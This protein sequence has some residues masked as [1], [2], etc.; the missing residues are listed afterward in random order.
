M[1]KTIV[2]G[3]VL[4][5]ILMA[6]SAMPMNVSAEPEYVPEDNTLV[7]EHLGFKVTE[8]DPYGNLLWSYSNSNYAFDAEYLPN[9]NILY[10]YYMGLVEFDENQNIIWSYDTYPLQPVDVERLDNGNTLF[11]GT[12]VAATFGYAIEIDY[13]KNEV[14]KMND[15][16]M[17]ADIERLPNGNNLISEHVG[18]RV[19]EYDAYDE[20]V[21]EM[22]DLDY[23]HDVERLENGNTLIVHQGGNRV[24]EVETNNNNNIV[25]EYT[26]L[27]CP[28]D[29]ERL[30]NG[31][32]LIA[33]FWNGRVIE[34]DK[35]KNIVWEVTGLNTPHDVERD[36]PPTPEEATE[37]LISD[38][39]DLDLPDGPETSLVSKLEMAI[40]SLQ[41]DKPSA[42][43]Q[44]G[45]FINEV[46]AQRGKELTTEQADYLIAAA[47]K[48]LNNI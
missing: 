37:S 15:L 43:G 6:F 22:L 14:W 19:R 28:K 2:I 24:I 4:I 8:V 27:N 34:V 35:D 20:V 33:D 44:L 26:G 36:L 18:H 25:W 23:I 13:E 45:A 9:G 1:R 42:Q 3:I 7:S 11:V 40:K 41:N 30:P 17:P 21:W 46:E 29:A 5:M 12:A 38:I 32:T 10:V 48:I 47:Q 16:M 31:N 39:E